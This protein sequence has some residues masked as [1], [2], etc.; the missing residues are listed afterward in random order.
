MR[1]I[2]K[3]LFGLV[4]TS[5]V[6]ASGCNGTDVTGSSEARIMLSNSGSA[7]TNVEVIATDDATSEV[8]A[9]R[10]V[11]VAAGGTSVIDLG[12]AAASYTFSVKAFGD[13]GHTHLLGGS[14]VHADLTVGEVTE[15]SLTAN[16]TSGTGQSV[17]R[18]AVNAAPRIDNVD[19]KVD[20]SGASASAS[21]SVDA[22]DPDGGQLTFF[23]SGFGIQGSVQGDSTLNLSAAMAA[24]AASSPLVHAASSPV[25]HVVVED[26]GGATAQADVTFT[27]AS[28]CA[29]C[30]HF[31]TTISAAG[32]AS[33]CLDTRANCTAHC[34]AL[35]SLP[36]TRAAANISCMSDCAQT[37]ATC[38]AASSSPSTQSAP[39]SAH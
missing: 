39:G 12:V 30:G 2:H 4:V 16:T 33:A 24:S 23:W 7:S 8:A 19:V 14:T 6:A 26:S 28:G 27:P 34:D 21:I 35:I 25:V 32:D 3:V 11:D 15:I 29:L 37:L 10:S 17:L 5:G 9:D 22:K 20:G 1:T 38:V 31:D 13:A 18:A 36:P